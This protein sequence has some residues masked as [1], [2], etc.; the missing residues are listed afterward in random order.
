MEINPEDE[1]DLSQSVLSS[2]MLC[3]EEEREEEIG[4]YSTYI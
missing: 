2:S 3:T 1:F 4:E